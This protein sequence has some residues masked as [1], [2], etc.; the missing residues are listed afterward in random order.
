MDGLSMIRDPFYRQ[1]VERLDDRLDPELFERCATDLLRQDLPGL[2][3]IRGGSDAGM[4]GAIADGGGE[5]YPLVCTTGESVIGNLTRSLDSYLSKGGARRRV[6]LATSRYLTPQKRRNLQQR[7]KEKGF[8]LLQVFDQVAFADRLYRDPAWCHALLSLTGTPSALSAVPLTR[9][10]LLGIEVVGREEELT[11]LRE[12]DGDRVLVGVSGSGKTF[13]LYTLVLEGRGLFLVS[14]DRTEI[15]EAIRSRRPGIVIADDAHLSPE[16]LV[17]LRRL[18]EET[19]AD[20]SIVATAWKGEEDPVIEALGVPVLKTRQLGLLSRD[21]IVRVIEESGVRGPSWLIRDVVDQAEGR[22]GLAVTLSQMC[23]QGGA[24]EVALGEHLLR[25]TVEAFGRLVG[26]GTTQV[27][28]AFDLGGEAGMSRS[29]VSREL[30]MSTLELH[31]AVTQLAVGGVVDK[32]RLGPRGLGGLGMDGHPD[33]ENLAVRP[34]NLRYALVRDVFFGETP[35]LTYDALLAAA[36][37]A[38]EAARTLVRSAGYGAKIPQT[39]SSPP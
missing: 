24:R 20:F 31:S 22:P 28:A 21:E 16:R 10:P 33:W 1:I 4:D 27:L 35:P 34:P 9:R 19:G 37:D 25:Y 26:Q 17:E 6:A 36:P 14:D 32:A 18:R 3:P 8:E 30:G 23:L 13:L 15:A 38:S 2:V 29:L 7:A 12:T 5:A 11:W 39:C